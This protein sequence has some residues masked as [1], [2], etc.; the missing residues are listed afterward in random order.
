ME[1]PYRTVVVN[2]LNL[3]FGNGPKTKEYWETDVTGFFFF[4]L[5][6]FF[7]RVSFLV[8]F[9][10]PHQSFT[11]DKLSRFF[12]FTELSFSRFLVTAKTGLYSLFVFF[13]LC[14]KSKLSTFF[15]LFDSRFS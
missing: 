8:F 1:V 3:C 11:I 2:Y 12:N 14:V 4:F 9:P 6:S 5:F 7:S 13:F 15:P 10:F